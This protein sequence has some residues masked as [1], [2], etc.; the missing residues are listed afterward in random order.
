MQNTWQ[1]DHP[2]HFKIGTVVDFNGEL[3]PGSVVQSYMQFKDWHTG[4]KS[5]RDRLELLN[6]VCNVFYESMA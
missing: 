6:V 4:D 3:R 1:I 5:N 2:D